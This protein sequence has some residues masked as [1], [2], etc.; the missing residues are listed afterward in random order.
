MNFADVWK[1]LNAS[2]HRGVITADSI[3]ESFTWCGVECFLAKGIYNANGYVVM[4]PRVARRVDK[5]DLE[6]GPFEVHG[7][8]TYHS[9]K[10]RQ[11]GFDTGHAGDWWEP[12]DMIRYSYLPDGARAVATSPHHV[13]PPK[14][15]R[16]DWSLD[17]VRVETRSLAEQVAMLNYVVP[18]RAEHR[19]MRRRLL[20]ARN[21]DGE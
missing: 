10:S 5:L 2:A 20:S 16:Q 14:F 17:R 7:G 3:I 4:P 11:I 8:I 21:G 1:R 13:P 9:G 6:L 12:A 19:A 15:M 18:W